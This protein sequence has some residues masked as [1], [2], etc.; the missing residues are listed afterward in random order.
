MINKELG[1]D[2]RMLTE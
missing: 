1:T 2:F